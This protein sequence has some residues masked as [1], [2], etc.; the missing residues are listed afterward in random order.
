MNSNPAGAA[1][2]AGGV[3]GTVSSAETRNMLQGATVRLPAQNRSVVT[4]NTGRFVVR[5]L[6]LGPVDLII[7]YTGFDDEQ[8]RVEVGGAGPTRVSVELK[9]TAVL[10]LAAFTVSSE[11]EGNALAVTEQKNATNLKNVVAMD[12][13]GD[14]T[15]ANVGDIASRLPGVM[16]V[17]DEEGNTSGVSIRGMASGLTRMTV[18]G[19]PVATVSG[20]APHMTSQSGAIYEQLELIKGQ[21]PDRSADSIGGMINLKTRSALTMR[22]KRRVD[23]SFSAK[24]APRFFDQTKARLEH[25]IHPILR[26][27]YQEIFDALGGNRNLGISLNLYYS[28]NVTSRNSLT[29]DYQNT[30][31]APAYVYSFIA[32]TTQQNRR[33]ASGNFV[34]DY[35]LSNATRFS[36]KGSWTQNDEPGFDRGLVTLS[37]TQSLATIGANGQPTGTG[38]ILPGFTS[39]MTSTRAITGSTVSLEAR[40]HSFHIRTPAVNVGVEHDFGRWKLDYNAVYSANENLSIH[41]N[42]RPDSRGGQL[43]LQVPGAAWE[44]NYANPENPYVRQLGGPSIFDIGSYRN[45]T[46]SPRYTETDKIVATLDGSV[47]YTPDL[48]FPL[49]LRSGGRF[50]RNTQEIDANPFRATFVGDNARLPLG[51]TVPQE[52]ELQTGLKFPFVNPQAS[53]KQVL[54]DRSLWSPDE[55]YRVQQHYMLKSDVQEDTTAAFLMGQTKLANRLSVIGGVRM[56]RTAVDSLGYARSQTL[57]TAAQ[58][59]DPAA[60]AEQDYNNPVTASGS[61]TRWFPS[62][63]LAYDLQ[64]NLKAV[65]SWSTCYG[66]P[67]FGSLVPGLTVND[68]SSTVTVNNPAIGPQYSENIDLTLQYYIRPAG[69]LS[70]GFFKK[71][72]KDYIATFN[73]GAIGSGPDNGYSGDYAGYNL[74]SRRNVGFAE[75]EGWEAEYRQQFTALPGLLKGLDFTAAYTRLT[76]TGDYGSTGVRTSGQIAGFVPRTYNFSLG[77]NYRAFGGRVLMS[78]RSNYLS[79]YSATVPRNEYNTSRTV[80]NVQTSY[81]WSPRVSFFANIDNLTDEP[82]IL[83]RYIESQPSRIRYFGATI[84][85]GATGRF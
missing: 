15:F 35:R 26:L 22:E 37:A 20:R 67:D 6:P 5:D 53:Y 72:I 64:P 46:I 79:T 85:F 28:E 76:A 81:R 65:G 23:Y 12:A 52:F 34:V 38:V 69:V 29:Y 3:I 68:A 47:A 27:G 71:E 33:V 51:F 54:N 74:I 82:E 57:A 55:Y 41:G 4:D 2:G 61:Y 63:H 39:G 16:A 66:R 36:F 80:W 45:V 73:A 25:P 7:S 50:N 78:Y 32:E 14:I 19:M 62:L 1:D 30:T 70:V 58:I 11:R 43:T 60:R 77:Y 13:F 21:L 49:V 59:P 44:L 56:E 75:I 18:D 40:H 17:T 24:W 83:Y 48:A 10:K 31:A 8:R 84:V 9:S 42:K